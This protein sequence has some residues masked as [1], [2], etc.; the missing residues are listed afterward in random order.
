M[1]P[2]ESRGDSAS[3]VGFVASRTRS[4]RSGETRFENIALRQPNWWRAPRR[5]QT[6]SACDCPKL[7][8]IDL[9]SVTREVGLPPNDADTSNRHRTS[10]GYGTELSSTGALRAIQ[11]NM[12]DHRDLAKRRFECGIDD[13]DKTCLDH[14]AVDACSPLPDAE[15][16]PNVGQSQNA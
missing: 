15:L 5:S 9:I 10:S 3:L 14:A 7:E 8:R 11:A 6:A 16:K 1:R 12:E 13:R 2:R 4:L